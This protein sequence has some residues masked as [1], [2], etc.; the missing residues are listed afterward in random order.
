MNELILRFYNN[1][2]HKLRKKIHMIQ[3]G[4]RNNKTTIIEMLKIKEI[5]YNNKKN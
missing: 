3:N 4:E 1:K 2:R 5:R